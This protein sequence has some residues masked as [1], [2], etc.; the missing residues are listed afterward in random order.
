MRNKGIKFWF[1]SRG[2]IWNWC[3]LPA[4]KSTM[5]KRF[6]KQEIIWRETSFLWSPN[7]G[8]SFANGIAIGCRKYFSGSGADILI[9]WRRIQWNLVSRGKDDKEVSKLSDDG[10]MWR[11]FSNHREIL[12]DK[13]YHGLKDRVRIFVPR[14]NPIN[15]FLTVAEKI[16]IRLFPMME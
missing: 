12:S 4:G 10:E 1:L 9:F 8:F 13:D 15:K 5:R 16:E 11:K 7:W 2:K 6:G 14:K 3:G